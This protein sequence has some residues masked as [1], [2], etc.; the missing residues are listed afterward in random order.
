MI[1][2]R[3]LSTSVVLGGV[4]SLIR[5]LSVDSALGLLITVTVS[6][7]VAEVL[8]NDDKED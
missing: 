1:A 4:F 3:I 6:F 8:H 7:I 5:P 2:I